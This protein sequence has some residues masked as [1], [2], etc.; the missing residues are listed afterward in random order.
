MKTRRFPLLGHFLRFPSRASGAGS[1][2]IVDTS[3]GSIIFRHR[4]DC[5]FQDFPSVNGPGTSVH[6]LAGHRR[7][8]QDPRQFLQRDQRY[9]GPRA[10]VL[11]P[12]PSLCF[13]FSCLIRDVEGERV[14]DISAKP[15]RQ[16]LRTPGEV[17]PAACD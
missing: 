16:A 2:F 1:V 4:A 5:R 7:K 11:L 3:S 9:K 15:R 6:Q 12:P 8:Q 10:T 17:Q 14:P 13:S